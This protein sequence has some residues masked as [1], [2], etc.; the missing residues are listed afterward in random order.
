MYSPDKSSALDT[1]FSIPHGFRDFVGVYSVIFVLRNDQVNF[2]TQKCP[3]VVDTKYD[4][5]RS[6]GGPSGDHNHN[7]KLEDLLASPLETSQ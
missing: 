3:N 4:H 6:L 5:G 2:V 1:A 7:H